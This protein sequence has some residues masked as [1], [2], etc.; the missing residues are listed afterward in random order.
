L[1][2]IAIALNVALD[3]GVLIALT[4]VLSST[5]LLRPHGPAGSGSRRASG[6]SVADY[7]AIVQA[8]GTRHEQLTL[9]DARSVGS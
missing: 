5:S 9:A 1:L 7:V 3:L 6:P 2:S 4:A 8:G